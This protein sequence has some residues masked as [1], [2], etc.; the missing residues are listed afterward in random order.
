M[1]LAPRFFAARSKIIYLERK[2]INSDIDV[3]WSYSV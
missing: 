2:E 1:E 3:I